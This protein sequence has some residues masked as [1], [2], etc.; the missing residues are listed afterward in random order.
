M[1][2]M[3]VEEIA[4]YLR[5]CIEDSRQVAHFEI[6]SRKIA[7]NGLFFALKGERA[8]GHLFLRE[9]AKRG[10]LAAVVEKEYQGKDFGLT[11]IKV[12]D[13]L[14]AMQDLA[15]KIT[16]EKKPHIVAI[17]GSVGK[18]TTKEFLHTLL[19]EKGFGKNVGNLNSNIGLALTL[20]N[21]TS[22]KMVVE[23]GINHPGE[24]RQL[25]QMAPPDSAL[26]TWISLAHS[27]FFPKGTEDILE[28]KKQIFSHLKTRNK[29]IP[30]EF[31]EEIDALT[32]SMQ[33]KK[34]DIF[35]EQ[36]GD[37]FSLY[38]EGKKSPF[39]T[40]PFKEK[41]FV[42]N[43][44]A[45]ASMASFYLPM[46]EIIERAS[47]LQTPPMRF[48][49][50][51]IDG[52]VFI[53]DAYNASPYSVKMA[54]SSLDLLPSQG[55]KIGVLGEMA[56]LGS[57]SRKSH[58]EIGEYAS[59]H[60]D[61]LFCLGSKCHDMSEMFTQEGKKAYLC[62]SHEEIVE[63]M[64]SIVREGDLVLVKGSRKMEMEKVIEM[65]EAKR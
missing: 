33:N 2:G 46:E 64:R 44:L 63:K 14:Q 5:V 17:T 20:L 40:L 27:A 25:V 57:F 6:D 36:K 38:K 60:L 28:E 51:K 62:S 59:S 48:E 43:F 50:K 53:N 42:H 45:A 47:L 34:A 23:M 10:A 55:R 3:L 1:K 18:T 49:K 16:E 7:N 15:Q 65:I 35:L 22:K 13:P 61:I 52:I 24:M 32:F 39:F 9:V 11:L 41:P 56:E 29:V 19:S 30:Y 8:D 37:L 26:I 21:R 12:K 58:E 31:K 4:S 54:L